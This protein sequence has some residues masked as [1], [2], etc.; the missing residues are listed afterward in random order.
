[1]LVMRVAIIMGKSEYVS[2]GDIPVCKRDILVMGRIVRLS[3]FYEKVLI[4]DDSVAT[5]VEA[6]EKI[7]DFL[8]TCKNKDGKAAVDELFFFY[9]GHGD[10]NGKEFSFLWGDYEKS[11][12]RQTSIQNSEIDAMIRQVNP[13]LVV[14][15]VDACYSGFLYYRGSRLMERYLRSSGKD[16]KKY[17][18][19]FSAQNDRDICG[20]SATS[21]FTET[22]FRSLNK[23]NGS[24]VRYGDIIDF[25]ADDFSGKKN[26]TPLFVVRSDNIEVF[27]HVKEEIRRL[28][29]HRWDEAGINEV[30]NI[31]NDSI[32]E[33]V[34]K[35]ASRYVD[36]S[37]ALSCVTGIGDFVHKH[38]VGNQLSE[39]YEKNVEYIHDY[40]AIPKIYYIAKWLSGNGTDIYAEVEYDVTVYEEK[41]PLNSRI[42]VA[43]RTLDSSA[44]HTIEKKQ[45]IAKSYVSKIDVP[46]VA[47]AIKYRSKYPNIRDVSLYLVP[48]LS[49]TQIFVFYTKVNYFT[50]GWIDQEIDINSAAWSYVVFDYDVEMIKNGLSG[51]I[52]KYF[53]DVV[54]AEIID[55]FMPSGKP[56]V[57]DKKQNRKANVW[58]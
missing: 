54:Y 8:D 47:V 37:F 23:E 30:Y 3:G 51:I 46:F 33:V 44:F 4:I 58:D 1:M 25:I 12:K 43:S 14:K 32:L 35:D 57:T 53:D 50:M 31:C 11:R 24:V 19:I 34:K 22:F 16:F 27:C 52:K 5:A 15:I 36:M 20:E 41:V 10:F 28:V 38:E 45:K 9:S 18:F 26:Q 48:L 40:D 56:Y 29:R 7:I 42:A 55:K 17:Y 49:R 13:A 39:L 6:K 2:I 21:Y